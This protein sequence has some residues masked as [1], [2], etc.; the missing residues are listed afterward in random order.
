MIRRPGGCE[1]SRNP[2]VLPRCA[3]VAGWAK[4]LLV[5]VPLVTLARLTLD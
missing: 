4:S 5:I 1:P 2:M 3:M